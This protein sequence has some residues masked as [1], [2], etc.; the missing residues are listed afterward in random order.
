[1]IQYGDDWMPHPE[2]GELPLKQRVADFWQRCEAAG[3]TRLPVTVYG[4]RAETRLVEDY[5]EAGVSRCV[6]RLPPGPADEVLP[7]L[8]RA[9]EIA[10]QFS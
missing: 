3:R 4:S 2:R 7:L 9:A 5:R 6:F 8:D 10:R 1:M